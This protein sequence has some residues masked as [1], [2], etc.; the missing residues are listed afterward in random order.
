[1]STQVVQQVPMYAHYNPSPGYLQQQQHVPVAV[2]VA[3]TH[4]LNGNSNTNAT[5]S[6]EYYEVDRYGKKQKINLIF[7]TETYGRRDLF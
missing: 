1:M 5:N 6:N 7:A 2:P 3:N 4:N